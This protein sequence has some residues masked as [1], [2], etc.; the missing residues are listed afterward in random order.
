MMNKL[1][2]MVVD[3][4]PIIAKTVSILLKRMDGTEI[5]AIEHNG[6]DGFERFLELRPDLVITDIV[7]PV[8]T[9]MEMIH[10]IKQAVPQTQCVIMSGYSE[11]EY[12]HKAIKLGICDYI[13]KP[14]EERELQHIIKKVCKKSN[15]NDSQ[16]SEIYKE[17][18]EEKLLAHLQLCI[19]KIPKDNYSRIFNELIA[20]FRQ[21]EKA[22]A[23]L[24]LVEQII[25]QISTEFN[26]NDIIEVSMDY[27]TV[28]ENMM[29]AIK[30]NAICRVDLSASELVDL[31]EYDICNNLVDNTSN[32]RMLEKYGYNEVYLSNL[33]KQQKGITPKKLLQ[34]VRMEKAKEIIRLNPRVLLKDVA[35]MVGYSDQLYF[36]RIFKNQVGISPRDYAKDHE[37]D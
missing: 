11:F 5:V 25:H 20:V 34:Q 35:E 3:D 7:M 8:M 32:T 13:L 37:K 31:I 2:I 6:E 10:K 16:K 14:V 21:L 22:K 23:S 17:K 33:F 1:R 36:S 18:V 24:R 27:Q 9:G 15:H 28:F 29:L 26:V 30:R 4:E 12:A 19:H